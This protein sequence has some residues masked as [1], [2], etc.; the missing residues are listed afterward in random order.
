MKIDEMTAYIESMMDGFEFCCQE[1]HGENCKVQFT[2][3][4]LKLLADR[5]EAADRYE[6][7]LASANNGN[8]LVTARDI[9]LERLYRVFGDRHKQNTFELGFN[10]GYTAAL[11]A[12]TVGKEKEAL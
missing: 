1:Q 4:D 12:V 9:A 10:A 7:M 3:D 6:A 2:S 5:A 11:D 8:A